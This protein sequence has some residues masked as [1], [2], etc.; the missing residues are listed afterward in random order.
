MPPKR[1]TRSTSAD[2]AFP[3]TSADL[4]R[5]IAEAIAQHEANRV[6]SSGGSGAGRRRN[7]EPEPGI[8]SVFSFLSMAL[9]QS[10]LANNPCLM[11]PQK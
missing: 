9:C 10:H 8:I 1:T 7:Q 3:T 6:D 5:V 2:E 4:A 11:M